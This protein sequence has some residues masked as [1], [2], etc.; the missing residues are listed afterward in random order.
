[1]V[2]VRGF[3]WK[4]RSTLALLPYF[5]DIMCIAGT[6]VYTV[7]FNEMIHES[8]FYTI[9]AHR[10]KVGAVKAM[11]KFKTERFMDEFWYMTQPWCAFRYGKLCIQE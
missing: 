3:H 8:M 2:V 10:T 4:L 5:G 9:S 1:V 6:F 11:Q 7:E